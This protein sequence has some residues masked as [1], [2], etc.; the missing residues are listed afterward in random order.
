MTNTIDKINS[1]SPPKRIRW[2]SSITNS[3]AVKIAFIPIAAQLILFVFEYGYFNYFKIPITLIAFD[4]GDLFIVSFGILSL[5]ALSY[6]YG[7]LILS[8]IRSTKEPVR[9]KLLRGY[10]STIFLVVMALIYG[11]KLWREWIAALVAVM[12]ILTSEFLIPLLRFRGKGSYIDKLTSH[13]ELRSKSAKLE[14]NS[15][16]DKLYAQLGPKVLIFLVIL[17]LIYNFGRATAMRQEKFLTSST[18]PETVVLWMGDDKFLVAPFNRSTRTIGPGFQFLL[19]G[20]DPTI[21]YYEQRI[22]PLLLT[23]ME[24]ISTISS[25][26]IPSA[27]TIDSTPIITLTPAPTSTLTPTKKVTPTAHILPPPIGTPIVTNTP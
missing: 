22:G 13:A 3:E 19:L 26:P 1:T 15:L 24:A 2:F 10:G 6:Y 18:N 7:N 11:P 16:L 5:G 20:E 21:I 17:Y 4:L 27:S 8:L 25:T 14:K 9:D 12:F 23:N